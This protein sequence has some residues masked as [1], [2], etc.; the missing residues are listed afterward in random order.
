MGAVFFMQ[1]SLRSFS[2]YAVIVALILA[3]TVRL[4]Y[5]TNNDK[6]GYNATSWDA[7]GYY[8]YLPSIFIYKD[9]KQLN[10]FDKADKK[11][12]LSGGNLYQTNVLPNGDHAFKYLSGV[13]ILELPF[14][15]IGH[16]N[17][18]ITGT[19]TDG[20][21]WPYQYAILWGAIF[22]FFLGL[23]V[24]RKVL[25]KYYAEH[26]TAL[27]ILLLAFATNLIQYVSVDGAMSHSFIFPLYAILIWWTIRWHETFNWKYAFGIGA[28]IGLA[29]ISRPTELI[30][31][32]IPLLW[33]LNSE[34][35]L[36]TKWKKVAEN[37]SQIL[38]ALA[39]GI[40]GIAPQLIYW[41]YATG[42]WIYDVG[43][44]WNFLNPWWRVLFGFE[45]G[46]FI[47]TPIAIFMILGLFFLKNSPYRK[48]VITFCLLNIWIIISWS[49]WRYGASYSTRA[50]SQSYP[51]FALPLAAFISWSI[52]GWKK[53]LV[54][55]IGIYLSVVNLFQI[56]QY[57]SL[58]LHYD[59]LNQKYY[60][61]IYLDKDP[62]PLDYS[63]MDT[64]EEIPS[65][66]F[67]RSYVRQFN[68]NSDSLSA[69]LTRSQV[70]GTS[71]RK[72]ENWVSTTIEITTLSGIKT[73]NLAVSAYLNGG[74]IK[75]K[76]FRFAVPFAED[77]KKM[78][79]SNHFKIPDKYDSLLWKIES[80]GEIKIK[81]AQLKARFY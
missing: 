55:S 7:F 17:A 44:K 61:A 57:N 14:F 58:I 28:I 60:S 47:Y 38:V 16:L 10:W 50:L 46:W 52:I 25:L 71:I 70:I 30:M 76:R 32:F 6:N 5:F 73:G 18:T 23:L 3:I 1:K 69:D 72:T 12:Q 39:G 74:I 13:A 63:F 49:D 4:C 11:Y 64:D 15:W 78:T 20:F 79:Y 75:E 37:R 80:F 27:T 26:V 43:S 77:K 29:T 22:Y 40:I 2:F 62:T 56:W 33:S 41:K 68:V 67:D 81:K 34:S 59:H 45:K 21:S 53:Y 48:A 51:V 65:S 19:T 9:V 8:M 31:I 54:Y 35:T 36:R 42:S 24:L 66:L